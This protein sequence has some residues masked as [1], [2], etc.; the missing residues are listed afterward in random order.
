ELTWTAVGDDGLAGTA[1]TYDIRY[2]TFAITE[3]T[4]DAAAAAIDTPV[5][6]PA[7]SPES[8]EI[9]GLEPSTEYYFAV[10]VGDEAT[11]WSGLSNVIS[12]T[13]ASTLSPILDLEAQT[14]TGNGQISLT[15]TDSP[16]I[17]DTETARRYLIRYAETAIN[18]VNLA[19][20]PA[21]DTTLAP[22][23]A[24]QSQSVTLD[25]L[26]PDQRYYVTVHV[27]DEFDGLS[28]ASNNDSARASMEVTTGIDDDPADG[29]PR[30]FELHQNYP[31]PFNPTTTIEYSLPHQMHVSISVYNTLGRRVALLID[32]TQSA[33]P[34]RVEW[35]AS[36][37]SGVRV[38]SGVYFYRVI[39][40]DIVESRKMVLL[41]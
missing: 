4:F 3:G 27:Y 36:D 29:L 14:G 1:T 30:S 21:L 13:T 33:G 19:T 25:G 17:V 20:V 10:K 23:P 7:G 35:D 28:P 15:W 31:N 38:A 37:D 8:F 12:R 39:A 26:V 22:P 6:L 18:S 16:E 24:G 2:A 5:P 9:T 40:G 11:N 32:R 41:K 34:H